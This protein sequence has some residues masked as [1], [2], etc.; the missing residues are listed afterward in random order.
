MSVLGHSSVSPEN[1][2]Y[3]PSRS[4]LATD[5]YVGI[6]A[7]RPVE[8]PDR[9][10][11]QGRRACRRAVT[12]QPMHIEARSAGK[13]LAFSQIGH[14]QQD[15]GT[16]LRRQL[17]GDPRNRRQ[18]GFVPGEQIPV[19]RRQLASRWPDEA[20]RIAGAGG[21]RPGR[22]RRI[23]MQDDVDV[24]LARLAVDASDRIG[25]P[26]ELVASR[27]PDLAAILADARPDRH[28]A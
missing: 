10:F 1:G 15:R 5:E 17:L 20:D 12:Q 22:P 24:E 9:G 18:R 8:R 2:T 28:S 25:P 11:E 16:G 27:R 23:A 19:R 21:P 4:L 26:S 13:R 14:F 6:V 7:T 3:F